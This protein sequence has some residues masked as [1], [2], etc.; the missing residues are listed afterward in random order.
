MNLDTDFHDEL[1][2]SCL[3]NCNEECPIHRVST[4]PENLHHHFSQEEVS[5]FSFFHFK[6]SD[7]THAELTSLCQILIKDKYVYSRYM[8][9]VG[10]TKQKFHINLKDDAFSK[11]QRVTKVPIHYRE[12]VYGLLERLI[13]V[14][15]I[16]EIKNDD[17]PGTFLDNPIINR[18]KKK[19]WK[20]CV[21]S[22][23]VNS[24][25]K[26]RFYTCCH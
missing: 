24:I 4:L 6:N 26:P 5:V 23:F 25:T 10:C 3:P 9:D 17:E 11:R 1:N 16:R 8:Y 19:T 14:G 21:D 13:Q 12:R 2:G 22:R 15:I 20:M 18:R 7:L